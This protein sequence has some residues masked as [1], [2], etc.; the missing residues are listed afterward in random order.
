MKNTKFMKSI[1]TLG[2]MAVLTLPGMV[3]AQTEADY[4]VDKIEFQ[5]NGFMSDADAGLLV[6]NA[7]RSA[8]LQTYLWSL[9]RVLMESSRRGNRE[10]GVDTLTMPV[11]EDFLKPSTVVATGNQ[12]TIYMLMWTDFDGEPLIIE[13]PENALG[14]INDGWQRSLSGQR[15]FV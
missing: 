5:K 14:Y 10:M 13:F 9:P 4:P 2:V 6:E 15:Q 12:S 11:T 1:V 8:G 3:F 7:K